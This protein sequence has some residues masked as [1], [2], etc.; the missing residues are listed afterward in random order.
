MKTVAFTSGFEENVLSKNKSALWFKCLWISSSTCQNSRSKLDLRKD[1]LCISLKFS[2]FKA[3]CQKAAFH[4]CKT[5]EWSNGEC[6]NDETRP[7]AELSNVKNGILRPQWLHPGSI[8]L[9]GGWSRW[10]KSALREARCNQASK[11]RM[12]TSTL[13]DWGC[14]AASLSAGH[15][16]ERLLGQPLWPY[17]G[18]KFLFEGGFVSSYFLTKQLIHKVPGLR[19]AQTQFYWFLFSKD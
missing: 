16:Q 15:H 8:C 18:F 17:C 4:W 5:G 19:A 11:M 2:V 6:S 12:T 14:L 1:W 13:V 7:T 9:E 3:R 10:L